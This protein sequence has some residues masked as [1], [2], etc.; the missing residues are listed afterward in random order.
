ME[1]LGLYEGLESTGLKRH[2]LLQAKDIYRGS[3]YSNQL[4][5]R[6]KTHTCSKIL[7]AELIIHT[8][9]HQQAIFFLLAKHSLF[10]QCVD[11]IFSSP[12]DEKCQL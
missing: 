2:H 11:L 10:L 7:Q 9:R 12:S 3:K 4:T 5:E 6:E 8:Q 1:P